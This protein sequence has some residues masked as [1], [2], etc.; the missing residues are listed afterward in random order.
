M[1]LIRYIVKYPDKDK[2]TQRWCFVRMKIPPR[3]PQDIE[4]EGKYLM[5]DGQKH[6]TGTGDDLFVNYPMEEIEYWLENVESNE[7]NKF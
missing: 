2:P 5:W 1:K 6:W 3:F 7:A 4:G